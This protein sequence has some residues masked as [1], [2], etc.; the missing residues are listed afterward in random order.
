MDSVL[1]DADVFSFILKR[2]TRAALYRRHIDGKRRTLCFMTLAELHRWV[3]ERNWGVK[4][5]AELREKLKQYVILHSDDEIAKRYAAVRN[6]KGYPVN[7]GDAWIA[8]T[9]LR[10][11]LPLVTHNRKHFERIPGLAVVSEA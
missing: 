4:R 8:A 2:D 7:L 5:V 11:G 9:A 3:I 6:I 10:H 1:V